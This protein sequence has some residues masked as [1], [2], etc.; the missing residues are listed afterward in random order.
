MSPFVARSRTRL[1]SATAAAALLGLLIYVAGCSDS[2]PKY[3]MPNKPLGE[4]A[5]IVA[6][7]NLLSSFAIV[8][9]D[10]ARVEAPPFSVNYPVK[11]VPGERR[12]TVT[13]AV[14]RRQSEWSFVYTFHAGHRYALSASSALS[15]GGLKL[16]DQTTNTSTVL[17]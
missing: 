5:V 14:G 7:Y 1:P 12:I 11:V 4:V 15:Q 6:Q 10:G 8:E 3:V 9:V 16:T 2:R 17:D 13:G